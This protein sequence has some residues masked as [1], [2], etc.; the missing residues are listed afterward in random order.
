CAYSVIRVPRP[1]ARIT[2]FIDGLD[3]LVASLVH[4]RHGHQLTG[5]NRQTVSQVDRAG[6]FH[7]A[8]AAIRPEITGQN[9]EEHSI[10]HPPGAARR[11]SYG[12]P[13]GRE[14][15]ARVVL[16]AGEPSRRGNHDLVRIRTE[17]GAPPTEGAVGDDVVPAQAHDVKVLVGGPGV[18]AG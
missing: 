7:F 10:S 8:R 4:R 2:A 14:K 9:R 13:G 6:A 1:P 15:V 18:I 12:L 17:P 11:H 5:T 16:L 3:M